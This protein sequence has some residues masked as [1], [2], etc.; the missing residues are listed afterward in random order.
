MCFSCLGFCRS[1]SDRLVPRLFFSCLFLSP[2]L[3]L[4]FDAGIRRSTSF[5]HTCLLTI[6]G[7]GSRFI[8]IC[9]DHE[10]CE[11]SLWVSSPRLERSAS[12]HRGTCTN[13]GLFIVY[14]GFLLPKNGSLWGIKRKFL[15]FDWMVDEFWTQYN[16]WLNNSILFSQVLN[17]LNK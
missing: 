17:S 15:V 3:A 12:V 14:N 4:S 1:S 9:F 13:G 10:R 5:S 16:W 6:H 8:D 2:S 11:E 7:V